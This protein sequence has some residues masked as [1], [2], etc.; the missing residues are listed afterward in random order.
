[1]KVLNFIEKICGRR[2]GEQRSR[3]DVL[4]I[5]TLGLTGMT[6][7]D[8]LRARAHGTEQS[9]PTRK[10]SVI[11][12]FLEGGASQYE[13]FDPKNEAPV[14]I[15]SPLDS[16]STRLPGVQFCSLF[17]QMAQVA[18]RLAIVRSFTHSDGDHG[19]AAHWV[20]TGHPWPPPFFGTSGLRIKQLTPSIGSVV[21]RAR[22]PVHREAGVPT[23]LNMRTIPGYEGDNAAWLGP[24]AEPFHVGTGNSTLMAN[25]TLAIPR[26]RLTDRLTLMRSL[27]RLEQS[28]DQNSAWGG[29]DEFQDQALRVIT[30]HAR[31]AFD[32][33]REEPR[34]RERY[35]PGLGQE[36]LLAR[37]LCEA[38]VGFVTINNSTSGKIDGWDHHIDIIPSC[39]FL[40]PPLDQAVSAFIDDVRERGLDEEI[41]LVI[42][43]EF[44]RTPR[45]NKN[46]GRDHW[47][48]IN[49]LILAGGGLKM[50]QTIGA[51]D[52]HG[53]YPRER[54]I[55]P[56]DLMAT[57][58]HVL[59]IEQDL[60]YVHPSGR[61]ISMIHGDG[62]P[63]MEL[64]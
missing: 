11:L 55:L 30:G 60:Q 2:P 23:Y 59:G 58:F 7:A 17:P 39:Q 45:M 16:I 1:M 47:A 62:R 36:L 12:L 34:L 31:Q 61:P 28:H 26:D 35:G 24:A 19:G 5:G 64:L 10:T 42:T 43:G 8:L 48:P 54:P 4:E 53:A 25:M 56:E 21:A 37:R 3:R 22:G 18:D 20:K 13:T 46:A 50:G 40:C 41:L 32:L 33:T 6:L 15:R 57:C 29:V 51:S 44:G 9:T 14:E 52:S 27:D 49:P 63:I 38:G